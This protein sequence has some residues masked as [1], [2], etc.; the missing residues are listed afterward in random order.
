MSRK[1]RVHFAGALY[2]VIARGIRVQRFSKALIAGVIFVLGIPRESI[3][4]ENRNREGYF[5]RGI[6][7]YL[8]RRL[9]IL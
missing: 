7:G 3:Y 2:H 1:P 5:G 4:S 9:G 6:V 8:A